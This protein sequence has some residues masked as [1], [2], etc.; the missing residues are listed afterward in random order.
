[1]HIWW[2]NKVII[3]DRKQNIANKTDQFYYIRKIR[4]ANEPQVIIDE[5]V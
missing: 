3:A 2:L 1:M 5:G 4:E